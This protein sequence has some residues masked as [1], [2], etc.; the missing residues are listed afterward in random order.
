MTSSNNKLASLVKK[1]GFQT[2][3][4]TDGQVFYK[5]GLIDF[6]TEYD[7]FKYLENQV[8]STL[9]RVDTKV[10]SATDP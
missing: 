4:S 9:H 3:Q 6:L 10:V 1:T 5:I 2:I 7:N 8:K